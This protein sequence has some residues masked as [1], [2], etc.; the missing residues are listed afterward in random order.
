MTL[1]RITTRKVASFA[2]RWALLGLALFVFLTPIVWLVLLSFK[3]EDQWV[4]SPPDWIPNEWTLFSWRFLFDEG[5][6]A[7][8]I[9]GGRSAGG[10][11]TGVLINSLITVCSATAAAMIIGTLAAFSMSKFRTGGKNFALWVLSIRFL[12]PIIFTVPLLLIFNDL[13]LVNTYQGLILIYTVFAVGFVVWMMK[14]FFDE[15]P[16]EVEESA[17]VDGCSWFGLMWR[18]SLPLVVPGF[19]AVLALTFILL[20]T[21]LLFAIIFLEEDKHTIPVELFSFFSA[22][23]GIAWGPQAA[24]SILSIAPV[25]AF[26]IV[27]QRYLIR[28]M[29]FGAVRE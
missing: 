12:P 7:R 18:I 25:L 4:S 22:S 26:A 21:E 8:T 16:R 5:T 3:P 6:E 13:G 23:R 11:G 1:R 10:A 27:I 24:L 9:T 2:A 19:V 15:V 28:G 29:T 17:R 20:W 14:G